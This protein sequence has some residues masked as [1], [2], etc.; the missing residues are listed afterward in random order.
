MTLNGFET[1][2]NTGEIGEV[3]LKNV[4]QALSSAEPGFLSISMKRK[5]K[6]LGTPPL[7]A[8]TRVLTD[9]GYRT[10]A[11]TLGNEV[12]IW[13][14]VR[15]ATTQFKKTGR[16]TTLCVTLSNGRKVFASPDHPFM[17]WTKSGLKRVDAKDLVNGMS[18]AC[19]LPQDHYGY[20]FNEEEYGLGF[21]FGD[22]SIREG[23]GELSYHVP[24]KHEAF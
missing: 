1:F 3:F 12:K 9:N 11:S 2:K 6:H 7:S 20:V 4:E 17:Q 18:I 15:W 22:G 19:D 14:G 5:R 21:V 10:I 24:E 13:T 23:R 8:S 16:C